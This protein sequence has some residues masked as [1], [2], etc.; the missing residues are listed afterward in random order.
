MKSHGRAVD[1]VRAESTRR[2]REEND[3]AEATMLT[4]DLEREVMD[5]VAAERVQEAVD[6]LPHSERSAIT[7]A[8]F[9]GHSYRDVA[10]M[11]GQPEGTVKSRIRSGLTSMRVHLR[12]LGNNTSNSGNSGSASASGS[13]TNSSARKSTLG[14]ES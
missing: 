3:L 2:R 5:L 13:S 12:D 11:L 7:L 6:A 14:V 10:V 9:G 8:Y 4:Y 1:L